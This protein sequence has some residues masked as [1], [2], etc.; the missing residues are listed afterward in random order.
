MSL[1]LVKEIVVSFVLLRLIFI[2][3]CLEETSEFRRSG[4]VFAPVTWIG[5]RGR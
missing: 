5:Y 3:A 2:S 1:D 4:E